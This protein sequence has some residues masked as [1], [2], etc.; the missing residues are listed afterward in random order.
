MYSYLS[1]AIYLDIYIYIEYIVHIFLSIDISIVIYF[2]HTLI[3]RYTYPTTTLQLT[4]YY[5]HTV[6]L[7]HHF[8]TSNCTSNVL[9]TVVATHICVFNNILLYERARV[10]YSLVR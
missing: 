6:A 1:I 9:I 5:A 7:H 8:Y 3:Y 4:Y 10:C 2:I